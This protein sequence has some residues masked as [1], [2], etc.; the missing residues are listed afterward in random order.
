M[1]LVCK[2]FA[3][4]GTLAMAIIM[5]HAISRVIVN[6]TESS[7]GEHFS[8]WMSSISPYIRNMCGN[9]RISS[10][11]SFLRNIGNNV[12]DILEVFANCQLNTEK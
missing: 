5:S 9:S 1:D 12:Y 8:Q 11:C 6:I 3:V 2:A 4:I 7:F 10:T